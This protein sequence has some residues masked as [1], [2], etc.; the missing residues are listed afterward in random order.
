M[1][2]ITVPKGQYFVMGDNRDNS[3]D[4]RSWGFVP[5]EY[6]LGK[7]F[8]VWLSWDNNAKDVRWKRMGQGID[9]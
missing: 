4:S 8:F 3:E 2:E 1:E 5:E 7:A 9:S 6:I